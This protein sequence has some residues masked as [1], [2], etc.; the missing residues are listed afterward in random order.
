MKKVL[1]YHHRGTQEL[2]ITIRFITGSKLPNIPGRIQQHPEVEILAVYNGPL[3]VIHRGSIHVLTAGSIAFISPNDPHDLF[4]GNQ[5]SQ[6]IDIKFPINMFTLPDEIFLQ[7]EFIAPVQE[8]ALRLPFLLTPEHPA[9][10]AIHH[11]LSQ[12][13]QE[14]LGEPG[15]REQLLGAVFSVCTALA[16]YCIPTDAET[17]VNDPIA[18]CSQYLADHY[19]ENIS[20]QQLA[21]MVHLHPNYLCTSFKQQTGMSLFDRLHALRMGNAITLL[22]HTDLPIAKVAESCGFQSASYF[23]Q[24]FKAVKGKT[25]STYRKWY[26]KNFQA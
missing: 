18:W 20:L 1:R 23:T 4:R 10:A 12:I 3:S 5:E 22:R 21:D 16:P 13:R 9:H 26:R 17:S 19:A 11:A 25:P 24:K 2:P 8:G 7:K 6:Y 14:Q 15:Y